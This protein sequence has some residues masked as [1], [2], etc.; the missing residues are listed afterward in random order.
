MVGE[1]AG[2]NGSP[3]L[4]VL[5]EI[6]KRFP[7][8]LANDRVSLDLR[9]GEVHALIGE[10]GAGKSTL[11]RVLYGMYPA[12]GGRITVRGREAKIGSP[13]D[14][15]ALGIGMVHQHFVLVDT[16]TVAEN[17]I[18]GEEGG[19]VLDI[20]QAKQRVA[21]LADSYGFRVDPGAVI[22]GLS[23]GEE[24]RVEILKALYRG[25]EIL[26]LDEPT[27]VLTPSETQDLFGNL[28]KLREA[29]RTIVFISHKL[30]EVLEIADRITVLRRGKV[31]GETPPAETTKA[32]LAE[33]MVGRPVLFRLDK[34]QV[35]I[36]EP[37]VRVD[38]LEGEGKLNGV[39]LE[40]RAGE[41]LG[42]AGV[43]GNGQRELAETLIGL[44][45][46][47]SGTIE[48]EGR[49]ISGRSVEEIRNSG[50]GYIPEDRH[51]QG[52]VL[53]M[54]LWENAVLGRHDDPEFSN[55]AGVLFIKRIKALAARLIE[56]FD[57]RARGVDVTASTLSGG[58]QQKLIL[59]RELEPDPKLMIAAQPTRGLD[60]G[61]IEFVWKQILDQK[62][63]GR[64]VLL[65]SAEL[66]EI[67]AL[68]DRIVTLYE[69]RI[70]GEFPPDAPPERIGVGMLGGAGRS[71]DGASGGTGPPEEA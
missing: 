44:R 59:A 28:R 54:T 6:T 22:E 50:V 21:E 5:D 23:V 63:A 43:E 11:M 29:G 24:Q 18:L 13:R 45:S 47:A 71:A 57:V 33:M 53:N 34:P 17:I 27:A 64:A 14:A 9:P 67:Y 41:I 3:P 49:S 42:V 69:G 20:D 15:I 26:I 55:R 36:G 1:G 46:P 7:G 8:V 52:L 40:V 60:V 31:V 16:F 66:D 37:V 4:V 30:D 56:L 68:S 70:T 38:G 51:D 2:G 65:I 32:K 48:L 25:V 10:N 39:S 19:A 58:N 12:D 61:A 35:E 62:A